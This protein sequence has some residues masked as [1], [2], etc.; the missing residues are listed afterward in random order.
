MTIDPQLSLAA[1][2]LEEPARAEL[3]ESL[4]FDYCCRGGRS[5]AEACA[6]RALDVDTVV[7]V[8]GVYRPSG[9]RD[10]ERE[11]DWRDASTGELVDHIVGVHHERLRRELP[12]LAETLAT[13]TRV[14]GPS[15]PELHDLARVFDGLRRELETHLGREEQVLFPG[16][17]ALEA[18][19]SAIDGGALLEELEH[20]H[21]D[22]GETLLVLRDLGGGYDR[23][24]ARCGTHRALIDGLRA[25]ERDLHQHIHEEN[26]I[27]FPRVRGLLAA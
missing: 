18:S 12:R 26:N 4:G 24:A 15:E 10:T 9:T 16:C 17:R 14:H 21:A 19:E 11:Y 22:V 3:F 8:L 2:V 25:L 6:Q 20:D 13:V 23:A 27:L 7:E 1:L 5:L